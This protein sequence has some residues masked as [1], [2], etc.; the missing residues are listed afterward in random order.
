[1]LWWIE[2]GHMNDCNWT[3]TLN[4]LV[5]KRTLNH[6]A[7]LTKWLSWVVSTCLYG[8]FEWI[9]TLWQEHTVKVTWTFHHVVKY[10]VANKKRYTKF[11]REVASDK[12][13]LSTKPHNKPVYHLDTSGHMTTKKRISISTGT[14]TTKLDKMVAYDKEPLLL[15]VTWLHEAT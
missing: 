3:R 14:M 12:M 2:Q 5:C 9:H 4:H 1:M 7:K 6:L 11:D 13:M 10:Q 15:S 8:A